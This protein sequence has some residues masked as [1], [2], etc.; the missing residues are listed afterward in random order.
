MKGHNIQ[1]WCTK[2]I[3]MEEVLC[4]ARWLM[5]KMSQIPE[6]LTNV[7]E[8]GLSWEVQHTVFCFCICSFNIK[9]H[10]RL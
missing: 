5:G 9:Q 1:F 10:Y 7:T 8:T 3:K 4:V 6:I 2:Q